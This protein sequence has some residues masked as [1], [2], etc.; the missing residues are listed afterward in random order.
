MLQILSL[1]DCKI[2]VAQHGQRRLVPLNQRGL[3]AFQITGPAGGLQARSA[4]D[5]R[6]RILVQG[7]SIK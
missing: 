6:L 2:P 5:R 7:R 3:Q 1:S 4:L